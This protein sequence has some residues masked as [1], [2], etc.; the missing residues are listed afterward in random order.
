MK[1]NLKVA[2][3]AA[4]PYKTVYYDQ[5]RGGGWVG[6][7]SAASEVG[8]I[9]AAV[10]RVFVDQY[11]RAEVYEEGVLIYTVRHAPGGLRI[12]FGGS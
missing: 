9:R 3:R 7:G 12:G 8:A 11:R 10:V 5:D 1:T 4:R 2:P 6:Q